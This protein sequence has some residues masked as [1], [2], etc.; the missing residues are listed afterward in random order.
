MYKL[1]RVILLFFFIFDISFNF[2]PVSTGKIATFIFLLL[3]FS[4]E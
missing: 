4:P 2:L 1:F 3:F